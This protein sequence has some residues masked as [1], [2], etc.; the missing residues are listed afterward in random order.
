MKP[1]KANKNVHKKTRPENEDGQERNENNSDDTDEDEF[2]IKPGI[3]F[4][5]VVDLPQHR[6]IVR[7]LLL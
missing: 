3:S 1:F 2:S 4:W 5:I 7:Y 6:Q